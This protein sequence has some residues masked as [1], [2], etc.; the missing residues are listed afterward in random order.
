MPAGHLDVSSVILFCIALIFVAWIARQ[1]VAKARAGPV[2]FRL[3]LASL[4]KPSKQA[5]P[6]A[7]IVIIASLVLLAAMIG[8]QA[9]STS[10][11]IPVWLLWNGVSTVSQ[12]LRRDVT[13]WPVLL[14]AL[15]GLNLG[16]VALPMELWSLQA[17]KNPAPVLPG[18]LMLVFSV[19][20]FVMGAAA[21]HEYIAGTRV[22]ERGIE[23]FGITQA[24][25]RIVVHDWCA[26]EGGFDLLLTILSPRL[27]GI[28]YGRDAEIIVP[29]PAADH[30]ALEDFLVEHAATAK[31]SPLLEDVS[32]FPESFFSSAGQSDE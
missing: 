8:S 16:V 22:R 11:L 26:H 10:R 29:V 7:Y 1:A 18:P 3:P 27:F 32:E 4:A 20:F 23:L 15:L 21:L 25:S 31:R 28:P 17:G 12:N 19:I 5:T 14:T 24:W 6:I 2:R 9:N 30:P 13:R